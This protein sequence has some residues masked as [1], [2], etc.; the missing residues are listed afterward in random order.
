[1]EFLQLVRENIKRNGY[2]ITFVR[3]GQNPNFSYTIGLNEIF[4]FELVIAGG[5]VTVKLYE[6]LFNTVVSGLRLG[7]SPES[8]EFKSSFEYWENIGLRQVDESWSKLTTLGVNDFYKDNTILIYQ[9]YPKNYTFIDIPDMTKK[10]DRLDPIW[11]WLGLE[12]HGK[13]PISSYAITNLEFLKGGRI[14]EVMRWEDGY[15]E[16]FVGP[17]PDVLDKDV[18]VLPISTF[19][20]VD[21]TLDVVLS[22]PEGDG[23]WRD[24]E[25]LEWHDWK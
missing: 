5:Y 23:I 9:L 11:R 19:I 22:L 25:D 18:R 12:W 7:F 17:G 4:G 13:I 8:N 10:W 3:D 1:M 6:D 2:H 20:G 24:S 16:M 14:T 21:P 15:W